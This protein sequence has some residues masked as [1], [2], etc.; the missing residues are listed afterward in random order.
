MH[1]SRT[2][3]LYSGEI[4][5]APA[6]L[7]QIEFGTGARR[8]VNAEERFANRLIR[9]MVCIQDDKN[10]TSVSIS[11]P[12]SSLVYHSRRYHSPTKR[13]SQFDQRAQERI[14]SRKPIASTK[15]NAITAITQDTRSVYCFHETAHTNP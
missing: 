3:E 8:K 9:H 4:S 6:H 14:T 13:G 7:E 15:A 10:E 12:V 5:S 1:Q 2:Y 11:L